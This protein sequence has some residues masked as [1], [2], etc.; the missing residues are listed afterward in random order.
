VSGASHQLT[1]RNLGPAASSVDLSAY[2]ADGRVLARDTVSVPAEASAQWSLHGMRPVSQLS[3]IAQATNPVVISGSPETPPVSEPLA[4]V[5]WYLLH[6]RSPNF[7]IFNPGSR[8][9]LVDVQL[10][11]PSPITGE[12][13]RLGALHSIRLPAYNSNAVVVTANQAVVA[14][15]TTGHQPGPISASVPTTQAALA[16]AGSVTRVDLFDAATQPAHVTLSVTTGVTVKDTTILLQPARVYTIRARDSAA[17][18]GITIT[19]D[20][21]VASAV[22]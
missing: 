13:L 5:S 7:Y 22:R 21:P 20:V 19:S 18:A 14:G 11:G 16:A 9:A 8:T 2:D 4:R 10:F 3:I 17:P 1:I 6:P 12:Q 15:P